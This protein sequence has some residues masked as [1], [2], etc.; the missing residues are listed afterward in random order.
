MVVERKKGGYGR[1]GP[2]VG[3][4]RAADEDHLQGEEAEHDAE[5]TQA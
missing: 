2:Q 1:L 4:D 5:T 3:C